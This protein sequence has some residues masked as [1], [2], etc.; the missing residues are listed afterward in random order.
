MKGIESTYLYAHGGYLA[1]GL[2]GLLILV[3]TA[4]LSHLL[5]RVMY[6]TLKKATDGE[7]GG[8]IIANIIRVS[9][10][11]AGFSLFMKVCVNFD[12]A[13]LWG[14]LG[15]GGIALSLGLQNT[16]SNLIGG[17]QVSLSRDLTLDDW[18]QINSLVGQIKDITWRVM[19]VQD[20][21]GN[22]HIIPNS[23]LNTT[24]VSVLPAWQSV[25][26]SL[27]ISRTSDLTTI[28]K[29]LPG[30]AHDALAQAGY[31]YDDKMPLLSIDGTGIDEIDSTLTL[32]A[33]YE[34]TPALVK[35]CT[36]PAIIAY[37]NS[38]RALAVSD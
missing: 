18:I 37:L 10:W 27:A 31:N 5:V 1:V 33:T 30:I 34:A 13:V 11:V 35:E 19:K 36:S 29:E 38:N 14:A 3:G 28:I 22:I 16:I 25:K 4:L 23:V 8:S 17:L 2:A 32:Y 6:R 26:L 12:T 15:I 24:A 21:S 20:I 7:V 9:I